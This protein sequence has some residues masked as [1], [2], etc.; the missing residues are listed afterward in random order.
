M[1]VCD[2]NNPTQPVVL[3]QYAYNFPTK[4]NEDFDNLT[5][6][7]KEIE[8]KDSSKSLLSHMMKKH[9]N[10]KGGEKVYADFVLLNYARDPEFPIYVSYT[11]NDLDR[12]GG[13][14]WQHNEAIFYAIIEKQPIGMI[15]MKYL[16]NN[17]EE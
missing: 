16:L 6:S 15:A 4:D 12:V 13:S 2:V 17:T 11:P 7:C 14:K 8:D 9:H 5:L 1:A 3:N 10:I